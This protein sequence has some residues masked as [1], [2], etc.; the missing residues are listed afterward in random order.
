MSELDTQLLAELIHRKC[1]CLVKLHQL[2]RRQL[3]LIDGGEMTVL[4]DLLA[5]K[6]RSLIELQRIERAL[7]P[8][9][10]QPVDERRWATPAARQDCAERLRR[11]ESLLQ[12]IVGQEQ[13]SERRMV[14]RRDEAA[15][16][17]Q[18]VHCAGVA[19]GAYTTGPADG[20]TQLDLSSET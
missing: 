5:T 10:D 2:G 14:R 11:C 6:Q 20:C 9:R 8:F 4:L 17:L 13:E 19:R 16:R 7:D 18:T 12:E 15:A 1:E 3:A